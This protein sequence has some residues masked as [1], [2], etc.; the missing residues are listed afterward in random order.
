MNEQMNR[1]WS[2]LLSIIMKTGGDL[3]MSLQAASMEHN[4]FANIYSVRTHAR[5][6]LGAKDMRPLSLWSL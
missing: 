1:F 6:A 5:S 3:V 4:Q 2:G